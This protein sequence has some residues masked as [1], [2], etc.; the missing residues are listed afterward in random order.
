MGG[1]GGDLK[2]AAAAFASM[3][4]LIY[5]ENKTNALDKHRELVKVLHGKRPDAELFEMSAEAWSGPELDSF[6]TSQGLFEKK[7]IVSLKTVCTDSPEALEYIVDRLKEIAGSENVFIF[8]ETKLKADVL[9]KFKKAAQKTIEAKSSLET[10]SEAGSVSTSTAGKK[11]ARAGAGSDFNVFALTDAFGTRERGRAWSVFQKALMNGSEPEELHGLIFWQLKT[12]LIA[13]GT[14]SATD[15]GLK[16]FVYSKAKGFARNFSPDELRN[17]SGD[18]VSLYHESRLG[19]SPLD[20][21]LE[22]FLLAI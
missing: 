7:L 14:A 20:L 19:G 13:S 15:A 10:T 9:V 16:P 1:D 2:H 21:A 17:M 8:V 12:I 4:Y 18:L 6:L 11:G 3:I 22:R 5:G